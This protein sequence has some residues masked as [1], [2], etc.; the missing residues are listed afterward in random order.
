MKKQNWLR[1]IEQF[2]KKME[3]LDR[4]SSALSLGFISAFGI[5]IISFAITFIINLFFVLVWDFFILTTLIIFGAGIMLHWNG[6]K[7]LGNHFRKGYIIGV[8]IIVIISI[9]G[10]AVRGLK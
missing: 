4:K 6:L 2:N 8:A 10:I 9:I 7:L 1:K 3:I 5:F